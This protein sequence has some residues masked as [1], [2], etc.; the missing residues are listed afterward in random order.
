[1]I[2]TQVCEGFP[3]LECRPHGP[4][5][6]EMVCPH[7]QEMFLEEGGVLKHHRSWLSTFTDG[8]RSGSVTVGIMD[9]SSWT[10]TSRPTAAE[11]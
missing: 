5:D 1:M 8:W 7:R 2:E 11:A 6:S 3:R 4:S 10:L 9:S